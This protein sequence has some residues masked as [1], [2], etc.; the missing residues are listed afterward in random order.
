MRFH[1]KMYYIIFG[2]SGYKEKELKTASPQK[3]SEP[4]QVSQT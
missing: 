1:Y 2:L 3:A 4:L